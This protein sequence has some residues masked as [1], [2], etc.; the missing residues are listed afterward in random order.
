MESTV[1]HDGAIDLSHGE[2]GN[3]GFTF[4]GL[5][6]RRRAWA[7][8]GGVMVTAPTAEDTY[9][10]KQT[11]MS[12]VRVRNDSV[13]V[14]PFLGLVWT[15][16]DRF[17]AQ[18]FLQ[19]DV[20]TSGCPVYVN[21]GNGLTP[22]GRINDATYQYLDV[23]LGSWFYRTRDRHALLKALAWTA[24]LHWN[25]ALDDTDYVR[26]GDFQ[27]GDRQTSVEV[28]NAVVG[29]H[30]EL[31]RNTTVT[32]GYATPIGGGRDQE[33]D[34]EVRLMVNRRFGPQTRASRVPLY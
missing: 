30:A 13:H 15:P 8:A 31:A 9:V 11:G 12:L 34:G 17:F 18:G 7:L 16:N 26:A 6:L 24:E 20:D 5:L 21:Q 4:K 32:L 28:F 25:Y 22:V 29:V 1:A 3:L 2:F 23:G 14:A 27:V 10:V 33:F 19:Y